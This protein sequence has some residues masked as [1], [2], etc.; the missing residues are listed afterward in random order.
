MKNKN[1]YDA[2]PNLPGLSKHLGL[3]QEDISI[4]EVSGF[5]PW[6]REWYSICSRHRHRD[7][8]CD[9]CQVGSWKNIWK[10]KLCHVF[11]KCCPKL[12]IW[13]RNRKIINNAK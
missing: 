3:T 11:Y 6:K 4:E 2:F 8:T 5:G 10:H 7:N 12:W 9:L 1:S 13:W